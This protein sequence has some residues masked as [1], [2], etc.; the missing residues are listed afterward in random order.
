MTDI[1]R[2]ISRLINDV[3]ESSTPPPLLLNGTLI[4]MQNLLFNQGIGFIAVQ[5]LCRCRWKCMIGLCKCYA[6]VICSR[7]QPIWLSI[8]SFVL[9]SWFFIDCAAIVHHR[10]V[11]LLLLRSAELRGGEKAGAGL[12]DSHRRARSI[13]AFPAACKLCSGR[14]NKNRRQG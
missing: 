6:D 7:Q 2:H 14:K 13:P 8:K 10:L 12:V 9:P 11:S 4:G 5:N 3:F 1:S